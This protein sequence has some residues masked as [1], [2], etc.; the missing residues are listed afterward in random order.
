MKF[1][2]NSPL[3]R[4][5]LLAAGASVLFAF[6]TVKPSSAQDSNHGDV[7]VRK[8]PDGSI[9]TYDT[10]DPAVN[11]SGSGQVQV[12]VHGANKP[13]TRKHSDGVV[14]RRNPDGSIET[15][16]P[17]EVSSYTPAPAA[18]SKK[19]TKR[20]SRKSKRRRYKK[21]AKQKKVST[22]AKPAP[23]NKTVKAPKRGSLLK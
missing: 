16:S 12:G 4:P 23:K 5:L 20:R 14:V 13:Y 3:R 11:S 18:R 10:S 1:N 2:L 15:F 9:S 21:T 7:V 19:S 8:N 17:E 6:A 22:K